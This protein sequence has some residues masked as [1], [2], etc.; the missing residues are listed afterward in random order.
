MIECLDL[1]ITQG[2]F[3]LTNLNFKVEKGDYI[4]LMGKTGCGKT[5]VLESICGLR[6]LKSGEI[7]LNG[8]EITSLVPAL[9]EI[10]YVPQD[11]A[12]FET[13]TVA[14]NI[15]FALKIR[16]WEKSKIEERTKELADLLHISYLLE[17]KAQGLSGG[18]KQRVALARALSFYPDV[19][20]LDEP[21]SALDEDTKEQMYDLLIELKENLDITIVH[22]SHS[23]MEAV[24]LASRVLLF[25][26]GSIKELNPLEI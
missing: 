21:L 18:E 23:K 6:K 24:K 7:W 12:L 8:K 2:D 10:G 4:V 26:E 19:L 14:Q 11:G 25:K 3:N 9:R 16:K 15:G 13:M 5:T 17:R 1:N 20:C 22:V